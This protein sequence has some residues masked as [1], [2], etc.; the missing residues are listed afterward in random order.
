MT[1]YETIQAIE[2][3]ASSMREVNMIV[4]NDIFRLNAAPEAKYGVFGWLQQQHRSAAN[5]SFIVYQFTFFYVDR[6]TE[7]KGN[8]LE[9]QSTGIRCLD[10]IIKKLYDLGIE[11]ENDYTFQTFNQ[12]FADECAG[13][14]CGVSL[15]VPVS[16]GCL[17]ASGDFNDDY[18]ADF[19]I[20]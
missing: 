13:V 10:A 15:A 12:R 20:Y 7:N 18:N 14:W 1:L 3:V 19:Y 4:R 16:G 5:S 8:E 17:D 6:L 9:V 11:A 2:R